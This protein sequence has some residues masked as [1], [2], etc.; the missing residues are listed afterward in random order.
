MY[1]VLYGYNFAYRLLSLIA[2]TS[3]IK[4]YVII[5]N[6]GLILV[7]HYIVCTYQVT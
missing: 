4:H 7:C 6:P 1:E 5:C 2:S 3:T